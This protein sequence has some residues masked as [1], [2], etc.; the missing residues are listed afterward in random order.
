M[1]EANSLCGENRGVR[2]VG[3]RA[4]FGKIKLR[5][6]WAKRGLLWKH[7]AGR[8]SFQGRVGRFFGKHGQHRVQDEPRRRH[9][10]LLR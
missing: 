2:S 10:F 6:F 5:R 9:G 1:V 7:P 8:G 4:G 3:G